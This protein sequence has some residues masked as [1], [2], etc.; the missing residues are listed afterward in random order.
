MSEIKTATVSQVNNYLKRVIDN[1]SILNNIWIQGEISNF[2]HHYSGHMYIT[3][4]DDNSV[5]KAVMF[6][7]DS[8]NLTFVPEDGMKILARGRIGVYEA[9]GVYQLY[10][11]EMKQDGIGDLYA[12][13]EKLKKRLAAEGIFST[14]YKKTIPEYPEKIGV[15]T[16]STGAAVRD[17]INVATRRFPYA[18]IVLYPTVVQGSG[19]AESIVSGIEYFN[20]YEKPDVIIIG[21]GGG[22]IEDLWGFN[23]ERV[24][25]AVFNSAIPIISA[26]GHETD[27]TISDFVADLR[28][29]T[30]SAAAEIAVPSSL[31][32][33]ERIAGFNRNLLSA[34]SNAINYRKLRLDA[35]KLKNPKEIISELH[36]KTDA[37]VQSMEMNMNIKLSECRNQLG[38]SVAALNA[39][40]PLSVLER[41]YSVALDSSGNLINSVKKIERDAEFTLK[42]NDGDARCKRI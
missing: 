32:L 14:E 20:K 13:F 5:L 19:A 7:N 39:L 36:L 38:E 37:L 12:A 8:R 35:Q 40:N 31:E 18:E 6:K 16:A 41:G 17:I 9:G 1:N 2:K 3:L 22:S 34:V 29:P 24:A 28:A 21:R 10:I 11:E 42:L 4:K 26:V 27:F 23:E 15:C 30:P 33:Y 25:Y